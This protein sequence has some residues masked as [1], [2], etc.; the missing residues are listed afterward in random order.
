MNKLIDMRPDFAIKE[1]TKKNPV[2]MVLGFENH[3]YEVVDS[4][5]LCLVFKQTWVPTENSVPMTPDAVLII[6]FAY[7]TL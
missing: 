6:A 2:L 3:G 1:F 7:A 5:L 4:H